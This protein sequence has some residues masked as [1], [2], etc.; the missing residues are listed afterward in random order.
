MVCGLG[1]V[2]MKNELD[3]SWV[4]FGRLVGGGLEVLG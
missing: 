4:A 2:G 3:R 1:K